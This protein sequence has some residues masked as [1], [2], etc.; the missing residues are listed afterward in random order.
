MK[1]RINRVVL[2]HGKDRAIQFWRP[3]YPFMK[4]YPFTLR[5]FRL[6][7]SYLSRKPFEF[8]FPRMIN[9]AEIWER[10]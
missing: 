10:R 8:P 3:M 6:V 4:S 1:N 7:M 2:I 5:N 9:D